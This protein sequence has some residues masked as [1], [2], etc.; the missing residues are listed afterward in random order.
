MP[1]TSDDNMTKITMCDTFIYGQSFVTLILGSVYTELSV[2]AL[3]LA[4][5][6]N[7]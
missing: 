1:P 5:P 4:M 2:I 7:G 3:T 6:K